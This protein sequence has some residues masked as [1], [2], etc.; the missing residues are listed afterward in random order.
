[1]DL[2]GYLQAKVD[3][4]RALAAGERGD[5]AAAL[6]KIAAGLEADIATLRTRLLIA[7]RQPRERPSQAGRA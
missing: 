1:M 6:L 3:R 2:V 7:V 4:C 5:T